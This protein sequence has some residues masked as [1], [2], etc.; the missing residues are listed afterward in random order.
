[1]GSKKYGYS[2]G[3]SIFALIGCGI[4][5][6]VLIYF[7]VTDHSDY[8]SWLLW[9]GGIF[10]IL[11]FMLYQSKKFFFPYLRNEVALELDEDKLQFFIGKKPVYWKDVNFIN[12]Y[13]GQN[14][15]E[16]I[17]SLKDD[18]KDVKISTMNIS[19]NDNEIRDTIEDYFQKYKIVDE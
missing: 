9:G 16:I 1:M 12:F 18:V 17:F 11:V 13:A 4:F 19:C 6:F 14:G 10:V 5:L 7:I 15:L 3:R 8:Q 2:L